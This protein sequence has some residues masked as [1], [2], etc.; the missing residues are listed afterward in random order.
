MKSLNVAIVGGGHGCVAIMEL[1]SR[2]IFREFK[3]RLVGVADTNPQAPAM[4]RAR[5]A[6]I[7]TA[8]HYRELFS[9]PGLEL[10]IEL[11]GDPAVSMAIEQEKPDHVH[12]L[13]HVT[14]KFFWDMIS[15]ED[16]MFRSRL[17]AEKRLAAERDRSANILNN[18]VDAVVVLD[19]S[20][21]VVHV[22]D[23]FLKSFRVKREAVIGRPCHEALFGERG[24][25]KAGSCP[26]KDSQTQTSSQCL[27]KELTF[28]RDGQD[29]YFEADYAPLSAP[30]RDMGGWL[31]TLKDITHRKQ[32]ELAL[33]KSQR[34]YKSLFRLAREGLALFNEDGDILEANTALTVM[35]GYTR[36]ELEGRK[37]HEL[38]RAQ[39]R[40]VLEEH[41]KGLKILGFVAVEMD[42]LKKTGDPL[43]VEAGIVWL[44]EENLF[45]ITVKDITFKKKLEESRRHYSENLE[46][47]VEK[48]TRELRLSQEEIQRQKKT[49]EGILYGTPVPM[50]VLNA[51]HKIMYWNKA[52]E[53]LTGFSSK[54][55]EGTD[56]HW[57]PFYPRKRPLLADLVIEGDEA[58]MR[59][60]YKDMNLR[61]SPM[62]EGGYEAEHFFPH[63][64][65]GG[66]HLY[67]NAAPIRD[68]E[69]KI[70]GSI[71]TYQDFSER[72]KMTQA[73]QQREAFVRNLIQNSIDGIIATDR[74]GKVVIFNRGAEGILGYA[75]QEVKD[76]VTYTQL[77]PPETAREIRRAFYDTNY[78][79]RGKILNLETQFRTREG[80]E[81]PV[82]LS[83]TLLYENRREVGSVVFLQDLREVRRLRREKEQAQRM[84]AIG[85]T[86]A[87]LAHYIKN[88]L[89]GLK[90]GAYVINSAVSKKD[91]DLVKKGWDMVSRNIDQ[92]SNIVLDMLV[93][94]SERTPRY[95]KVDPNEL[96][97]EVVELMQDRARVSGV[98]L[99]LDLDPGVGKVAMDR[100]AL[101][102][103]L[104][105][106]VSNAIDACTLEGIVA[107]Q[108]RVVLKTDRPP[109]WGVRFRVIDNGT[110]MDEQTRQK[111]FTDF[112]TTKGYKGTGLG[113]PVTQKIVKEHGGSLTFETEL[114]KGTTFTIMLPE[115]KTVR[116][117][118]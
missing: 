15:L 79:P 80:E 97:E 6:G 76:R 31:I 39:S 94:S 87:G 41:L 92:I 63:L 112:Y 13:D 48:R 29:R 55:M 14:A 102:R 98:R 46:S 118:A 11:T 96:A 88:I 59:D 51:D 8:T 35:L 2:D 84:A 18:L 90:G 17:E 67:F 89:N 49:V 108:G 33:E 78:G 34:K 81:I 86:V 4:I 74:D 111:L 12:L 85:R 93:Y 5:E 20:F 36:E 114:G 10:I 110:G 42:F 58:R 37:I 73:L 75:A 44:P 61:P 62:V 117:A 95:E 26:I 103:C 52:C 43:S 54:E 68:D 50:F 19:P 101:H 72:V 27:R 56:R 109:G 83:G 25:C 57:E 104:L 100:T 106:L 24:P 69:G 65:L 113:L 47:E 7:L 82:R 40:I 38:A 77:V 16:E 32:L 23:T 116:V 22:N 30:G 3:L 9:I 60:L 66:T 115:K 64:G 99:D 53:K 45:H 70:Q 28:R 71:I 107:G 1:A 105:N 91:I 21:N